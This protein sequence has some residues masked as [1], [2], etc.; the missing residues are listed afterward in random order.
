MNKGCNNFITEDPWGEFVADTMASF[1]ESEE[2]RPYFKQSLITY[3]AIFRSARDLILR[4]QMV[5]SG[6]QDAEASAQL[7]RD[8]TGAENAQ[9]K[10]Y[11]ELFRKSSDLG[12]IHEQHDPS[13]SLEILICPHSSAWLKA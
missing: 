6:S 4:C 13:L 9:E 1:I 8:L 7:I 5:R 10:E 11:G 12:L 3:N 2:L